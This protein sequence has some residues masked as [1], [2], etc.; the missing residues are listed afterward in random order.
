MIFIVFRLDVRPDKREDFLDGI[1]RYSGQVRD[2]PGNLLFSCYESVERANE[3]TVLA[4][5][6]DQAAGGRRT[7][8]PSTRSGSSAGCRRW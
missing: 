7:C 2:E 6:V 1:V 3:Y 4:N 5:Y 8:R